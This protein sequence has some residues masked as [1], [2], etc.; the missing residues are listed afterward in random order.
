M[1]LE[2]ELISIGDVF[3]IKNGEITTKHIHT[4]FRLLK[5]KHSTLESLNIFPLNGIEESGNN[6]IE[7][8]SSFINDGYSVIRIGNLIN[9]N[10]KDPKD[11]RKAGV[12]IDC[13]IAGSITPDDYK[14]IYDIFSNLD[15]RLDTNYK[16]IYNYFYTNDGR[17]D[18][19][20]LDVGQTNK[21]YS[22]TEKLDIL[23]REKIGLLTPDEKKEMADYRVF[24]LEDILT[25]NFRNN[26]INHTNAGSIVITE[27]NIYKNTL[28]KLQHNAEIRK[29]LMY[30]GYALSDSD[31]IWNL[32][33]NTNSIIIQLALEN[34]IVWANPIQKRTKFQ[35]QQ[36]TQIIN[37]ILTIKEHND[38]LDYSAAICKNDYFDKINFESLVSSYEIGDDTDIVKK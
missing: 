29:A 32:S 28:T 21:N 5:E 15:S 23:L 27:N 36:L 7:Y 16:H 18:H 13:L 14:I 25:K 38:D 19:D 1:D 9:F 37:Q 6:L 33:E 10:F 30:E 26:K 20:Y 12:E 8:Y 22:M 2:D 31:C 24:N 34:F 3:L 17:L 4:T 35:Q 11:I